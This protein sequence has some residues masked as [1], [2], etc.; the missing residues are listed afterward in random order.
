MKSLSNMMK[1]MNE[2]KKR[3]E[4]D[5]FDQSK[6]QNVKKMEEIQKLMMK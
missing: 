6:A 1:D 4:A 3:Q 5:R 2:E